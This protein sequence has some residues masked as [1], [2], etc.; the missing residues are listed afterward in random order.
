MWFLLLA[1]AVCWPVIH[2]IPL[3]DLST[4]QAIQWAAENDSWLLESPFGRCVEVEVEMAALTH[5]PP[6][7]L[8]S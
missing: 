7:C 1:T 5:Q 2:V 8:W 4:C 3:P 6:E